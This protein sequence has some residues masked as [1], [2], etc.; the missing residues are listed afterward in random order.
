MNKSTITTNTV[1]GILILFI[2]FLS[3][4]A[5]AQEEEENRLPAEFETTKAYAEYMLT[6]AP[7]IIQGHIIKYE[8]CSTGGGAVALVQVE[9]V[10]RGNLKKGTIRMYF[11]SI[12]L[13]G[14]RCFDCPVTHEGMAF[15]GANIYDRYADKADY[16]HWS[17]GVDKFFYFSKISNQKINEFE[18][19]NLTNKAVLE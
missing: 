10:L 9:E 2:S 18:D 14:E 4:W 3:T 15:G 7:V 5:T 1:K 16:Y 13:D 11:P 12:V 17:I 8:A 19:N 6:T